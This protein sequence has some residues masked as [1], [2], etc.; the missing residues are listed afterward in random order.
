MNFKLKLMN[1]KKIILF[2]LTIVSSTL[3]LLAQ[4]DDLERF[5]NFRSSRIAFI[6]EQIN[7]TPKEAEVFW[8]VYNEFD[9]KRQSINKEKIK[10]AGYYIIVKENLNEQEASE[11][12]DKIIGLQKKEVLLS[13]EYNVKFKA[14]LPASKV[15]KLY[16]SELQFKKQLLKQL[17]ESR[18]RRLGKQNN[19]DK[20]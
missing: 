20:E 15:L 18:P 17:K 11:I 12:A 16:Y 7:L 10:V 6:T 1:Y 13:E 19:S 4:N 3:P 2:L 14:V 5:E 8:P 9:S